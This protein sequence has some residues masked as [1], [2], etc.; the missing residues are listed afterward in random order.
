[1]KPKVIIT[2]TQPGADVLV[3]R[4][5]GLDYDAVAMPLLVT[6]ATGTACPRSPGIIRGIIITSTQALRFFDAAAFALTPV[7]AVGDA[8]TMAARDAGF[9]NVTNGGGD[10]AALGACVRAAAPQGQWLHIGADDMAAGTNE[11]L[12]QTGAAVTRWAVYRSVPAPFDTAR[13]QAYLAAGGP[14]IVSVHSPKG[15]ALLTEA[16]RAYDADTLLRQM[17]LLCLSQAVLKSVGSVACGNMYVA[18]TPDENALVDALRHAWPPT[19][20]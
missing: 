5:S 9:K 10:V 16:V 2:R 6:E 20:A 18:R 3:S 11:A 14:C 15:G 12:A 13:L 19:H 4:L 7:Y 1:M 17:F 8:T